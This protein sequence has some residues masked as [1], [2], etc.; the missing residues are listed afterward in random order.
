MRIIALIT[1]AV[2]AMISAVQAAAPSTQPASHGP[3][4]R[5]VIRDPHFRR[6]FFLIAPEPGRRIAYGELAGEDPKLKPVWD[7]DQWSSKYPL[8]ARP[9]RVLADG[10]RCFANKAKSV[11]VGQAGSERADIALAVNAPL[12]YGGRAREAGE[13]W[14][15][16]LLLQAIE[17]PPSLAEIFSARLRVE[18]RLLRS[19]LLKTK[20]YTPAL[21]AAQAQIFFS[22]QNRNRNSPGY[23]QYLW[24]GIPLYDD[25][26]RSPAEY[27][28]RDTGGT[29][30]FIFT[31]AAK[32]FTAKSAHDGE[33]ISIDKD[34]LPLMREGLATAW[35]RGFLKESRNLADY[36]IAEMNLGWEAP[37]LFDVE[38]Q[39]RN[40]G[41]RVTDAPGR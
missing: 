14:V 21:H 34:L 4:Q 5:Q 13:P 38:M 20:D 30:M 27:K 9:P 35:E 39:I 22:V 15:H 3:A 8:A 25:R 12:E 24:F 17:N 1:T 37:G 2:A 19:K 28:A 23:G 10:S 36:R 18:A 26:W 33:W 40:L 6:G 41:L 32:E 29:N 11:I 16:L 31:P 7:L